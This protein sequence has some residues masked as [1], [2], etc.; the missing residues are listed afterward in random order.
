MAIRL[1]RRW[2]IVLNSGMNA[3]SQLVRTLATLVTIPALLDYLGKDR[4]G[5]WMIALS[6]ITMIGFAQGG[7]SSSLINLSARASGDEEQLAQSSSSIALTSMI[8][9]GSIPLAALFAW[10]IPWTWL[11]DAKDVA[12][13]TEVR[14]L[15]FVLLLGFA[16]SFLANVPKFV[17]IGKMEGYAA[18]AI[19][20]A[21]SIVSAIAL[22]IAV[23]QR[24]PLWVLAAAF[25]FGRFVPVL[26]LG[27]AYFQWRFRKP[28]FSRSRVSREKIRLQLGQG[29]MLTLNNAA[30]SLS[31]QS[32]LTLIGILA[33]LAAAGD[34]ALVQRIFSIPMLAVGFVNLALWPAF[35]SAEAKGEGRWV[36]RTFIR[37][38]AVVLLA[39]L[40]F[41]A[42]ITPLIGWILELWLGGE[43]APEPWLVWGMAA[44]S[45]L[46]VATATCGT[47]L[48]ALGRLALLS[49]LNFA[50]M[51]V[52]LPASILLIPQ[53]GAAGAIWGTVIAYTF[54]L[55]I[56]YVI[57]IPR[58][59]GQVG[60]GGAKVTVEVGSGE[61]A[62]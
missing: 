39:A 61:I 42:V 59:L 43:H 28:I 24:Q 47:L 51:A 40:A 6:V 20:M 4:F 54:C 56:P 37:G 62:P 48:K 22:L 17:L 15:F 26:V 18:H 16:F 29:S 60:R 11:F 27:S 2:T 30:H 35:S 34:Y 31:I 25:S 1:T 9:A 13:A 14:L 49:R 38:L 19:D 32:D 52:N 50:M 41:T 23:W 33:T 21:A 5:L 55:A 46:V 57:V 10:G 3:S 36:A 53:I 44:W 8:F 58:I 7:L 45:V 12:Q